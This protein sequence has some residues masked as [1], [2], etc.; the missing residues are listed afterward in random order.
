MKFIIRDERFNK[1]L[2]FWTKKKP[3]VFASFYFWLAGSELQRSL[4]GLHRT[5][6]YQML[7]ADERMCR[8]AFPKWQPKFGNA[9]PTLDMLTI[10]MTKLLK[11]T[12]LSKNFFFAIDGLDEYNRDSVGKTTLAELM[13]DLTRSPKVKLLLSSRPETRFEV[14]FRHCPLLRLEQLT[15]PDTIAYVNKKLWSNRSLRSVSHTEREGIDDIAAFIVANAQGVSGAG[16]QH[17]HGWNQQSRRSSVSPRS[18]L[19]VT[20][21]VGGNL[22]PHLDGMNRWSSQRRGSPVPLYYISMAV[23]SLTA[24]GA[25]GPAMHGSFH[26]WTVF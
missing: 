16:S 18:H 1:L 19:A 7:T 24:S 14:V 8:A 10:A 11:S 4:V 6:L 12:L 9:E 15:K 23:E 3:L 17:C 22:H 2:A 21:R 25:E 26:S 13:L 20:T 5:L